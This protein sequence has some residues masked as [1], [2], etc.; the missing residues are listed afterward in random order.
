MIRVIA[1]LFALITSAAFAHEVGTI[2]GRVR[3]GNSPIEFAHIAIKGTSKGA[4][5]DENGVFKITNLVPGRYELQCSAV[6]YQPKSMVV[7]L[8]TSGLAEL[9]IELAEDVSQLQEVVVTGTMREVSKMDSPI[10]VEVY[11]PTL[12]LKNPTPN[13]FESLSV[14]NGV[15]PQINCNVCNTGD[16]HINGLEGPYTMILIDGM[17]IVSSLS[18]VYGLAGIPNSLVKRMEIVK[19]PASTLYGSEA[20]GGVINI[21]TK[22]PEGS[23]SFKTDVLITS[24][25][26]YNLDVSAAMKGRKASGLFGLNYFNYST[27]RDINNDNFTDVTLQNRASV[28]NKWSF[29][30]QSGKN[31]SI[32]ARYVFE[33][34]WGGELQWKR[35]HRGTDIYYGESVYTNRAEVL[36]SYEVAKIS[37][38]HVDFSFNDH[39]QDSYYGTTQYLARQKVAF[40]QVRWSKQLGS[41]QLLTGIPVRQ[42]FY[43]DN[44]PATEI[45]GNGNI[46]LPGIFIQDEIKFSSR[47]T[48]LAGIRFD[49]HSVHGGIYTPRLSFKYSPDKKTSIRFTSGSG[50]RVVNLFTEDHAALT[51]SRQVEIMSDLKPEQSWNA[52]LNFSKNL[53]LKNGFVTV[54]AS[55]FYTY[56]TNKIVGDFLTDPNKILYDNLSGYAVSKG[57]T[58][59]VDASF[60]NSLKIISGVTLMDVFQVQDQGS[61]EVKVPQLQ[62][63][64]FSGTM[65]T[66]YTFAKSNLTIDLTGRI[67]GPMYLPVVENDFR[68]DKSPWFA[69]MNLQLTKVI[70]S[71][72]EVYGG[73]KN[74][75]NFIP[76]DPLLRPFDPFDRNIGVD[77]P[78]GYTFD[79]SYNYAPVQGAKGFFGVR[80]T[81][82]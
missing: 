22:E 7:T 41:H 31:F 17:P 46:F 48:S 29:K 58:L 50:Y 38:M 55:A 33:D 37:G 36:G 27:L 68:P 34:R 6:G 23:A 60:A 52:N 75:L 73:V 49:H 44:T 25:G 70:S 61:G 18:T 47:W 65:T 82:E 14:V 67:N 51:G 81:I 62:A 3:N 15:Q 72:L 4:T 54:D 76:R 80:W 56:F 66:S 59:N 78:N 26:E 13:I 28:F 74:L 79:A 43:D 32:A 9:T 11:T 1:L 12:F 21:I 40:A 69:L 16:I 57:I 5:A 71:K 63:P 20:V 10:P 2:S 19:G 64:R 30:R 77:N 42:T 39:R 45:A 24:V 35:E 8:P 53:L